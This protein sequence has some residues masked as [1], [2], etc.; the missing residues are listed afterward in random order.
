MK[1]IT[2]KQATKYILPGGVACPYCGSQDIDTTSVDHGETYTGYDVLCHTCK[3][4]WKEL[5]MLSAISYKTEDGDVVVLEATPELDKKEISRREFEKKLTK[6]KTPGFTAG[7]WRNLLAFLCESRLT[8]AYLRAVAEKYKVQQ[9]II[10]TP[11]PADSP[12]AE[13]TYTPI[14]DY[15]TPDYGREKVVYVPI[16][17]V[18]AFGAAQALRYKVGESVD[19]YEV[20]S[21]T[22]YSATGE[23]LDELPNDWP[24]FD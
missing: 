23:E 12:H 18:N 9:A 19:D 21:G 7:E 14:P 16:T 5:R 2:Q 10:A 4:T 22:A 13:F 1:P 17:W 11:Y 15:D 6:L 3:E 8:D 24:E 20:E